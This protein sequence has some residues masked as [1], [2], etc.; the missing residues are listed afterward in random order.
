MFS[1]LN[2]NEPRS[3]L[4][5]KSESRCPIRDF[6]RG[7][8]EPFGFRIP[9]QSGIEFPKRLAANAPENDAAF[10]RMS[11]DAIEKR[12]IAMRS[13]LD[14]VAM[15]NGDVSDHEFFPRIKD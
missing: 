11:I 8:S 1:P 14:S 4:I 6:L 3:A 2:R 15:K 5:K 12:I 10:M 13:K 7:I 9:R